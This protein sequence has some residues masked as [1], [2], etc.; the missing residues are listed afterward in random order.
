M[1]KRRTVDCKNISS[2]S[3]AN[4]FLFRTDFRETCLTLHGT[5]IETALG[6]LQQG[7]GVLGDRLPLLTRRWVSYVFQKAT[8]AGCICKRSVLKHEMNVKEN[9]LANWRDLWLDS[10][11]RKTLCVHINTI[12]R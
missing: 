6:F 3:T 12:S 7:L 10:V 11:L 8:C 5:V 4:L 1:T 2:S 9:S